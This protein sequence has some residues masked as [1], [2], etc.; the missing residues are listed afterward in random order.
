MLEQNNFVCDR[1][2]G[3]CC[4]KYIVKLSRNDIKTIKKAGYAEDYFVDIDEFLP[5]PTKF[6]LKK[7]ENRWCVFLTRNKK[8]VYS[9][10]IYNSRPTV[11]QRYPFLKKN[12]E[13]CK[14]T[15]FLNTL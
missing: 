6:V 8:G 5:E 2:C 7:K 13:S 10:K 14:P 4:I 3:E 1:K 12:I 9:C 15:S 11:C